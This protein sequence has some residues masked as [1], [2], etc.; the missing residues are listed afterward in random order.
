MYPPDS[1]DNDIFDIN[2]LKK[3][4]F[5]ADDLWLK[6]HTLI[7][8]Y[9]VVSL[10]TFSKDLLNVGQTQKFKLV[11]YNSFEGGNDLQLNNLIKLYEIKVNNLK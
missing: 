6:I 9:E 8:G 7:K 11:K 10:K 1:Y 3:N 4:C 2:T 5:H